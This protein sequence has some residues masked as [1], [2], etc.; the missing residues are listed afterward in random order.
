[1]H[2]QNCKINGATPTPFEYQMPTRIVF[3]EGSLSRLKEVVGE[4]KSRVLVISGAESMRR[5]GVLD[6]IV[7]MLGE[8]CTVLYEGVASNP[9]PD[10]VDQAVDVFRREK[11]DVVIGIGGGSAIDVAKCV[12]ILQDNPYK[13][14]EYLRKEST[15]E[16]PG[17]PCIAI[18]TTAGT[19][20]EVTPWATIWDMEGLRKYSLEH[21]WM[22]PEVALI[23][24]ALAITLPPHQTALTG[25]DALTQAVEAY[26]SSKSQPISDMCALAAVRAIVGNL[27][28]ACKNGEIRYRSAMAHGSLL[29]GLAFSNT[30]TTICHSL[31]YPMTAH[32]GIPHGQAV[33]ITLAPFLVWNADA[34]SVKL[35]PLLEAM[36]A[37]S[38]EAA[39]S[40]IQRLMT[41][42][43]LATRFES[44][45]L[46]SSDI[47]LI[48]ENGFYADRADNNPR[49]VTYEDI[50]T[51]LG[52]LL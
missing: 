31:S 24:P 2:E 23:D 14:W 3:G 36:D 5:A 11:C 51:I 45:G 8:D 4:P 12:A 28:L 33:S 47:D 26:W 30:K 20:S 52:K 43:G 17:A 49:P 25:M 1:M 38:P 6:R 16:N 41:N 13:T 46:R 29:A 34:I 48:L 27:E 40:L 39:G 32:F 18:P 37:D 10:I 9:T 22:W 21:H 35:Q 50:R 15:L 42:I 7:Q 44:L 19:G